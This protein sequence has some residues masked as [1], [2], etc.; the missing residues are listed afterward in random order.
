MKGLRG[1]RLSSQFQQ[2][3]SEIIAKRLRNRYASL[4]AIISV[5]QAD[6]APDLKSAKIYVSIY[7]TNEERKL[8][9]FEILKENAGF[10]RH[11]LSKVLHLRTVPELRF[12]LDGT[13]EYGEKI[14]KLL[15]EISNEL[16][17][18]DE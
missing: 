15:F 17:D 5:T 8:Q 10:I 2:E 6:I 9:S 18:T 1:E 12:I 13:M 7:D 14:D 16:G 3:I 4:S 11:E